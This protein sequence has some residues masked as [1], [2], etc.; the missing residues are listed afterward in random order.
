MTGTTR[1]K[2][3]GVPREEVARQVARQ[4]LRPSTIPDPDRLLLGCTN[5]FGQ[6]AKIVS[7]R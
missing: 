3:S 6:M 7:I 1:G 2:T 5:S 4:G